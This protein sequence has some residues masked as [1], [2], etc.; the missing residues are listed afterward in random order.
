MTREERLWAARMDAYL[1]VLRAGLAVKQAMDRDTFDRFIFV[2]EIGRFLSP[3]PVAATVDRSIDAA[4]RWIHLA[5]ANSP[6]SR[7][8]QEAAAAFDERLTEARIAMRA[9]LGIE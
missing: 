3:D 9:D 5:G 2:A 8:V 1:E 6:G 4:R 7:A